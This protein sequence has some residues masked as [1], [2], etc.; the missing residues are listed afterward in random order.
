LGFFCKYWIQ[1]IAIMWVHYFVLYFCEFLYYVKLR[2]SSSKQENE[3]DIS[4]T[5]ENE[6]VFS[7][8]SSLHSSLPTED[9][10]SDDDDIPLKVLYKRFKATKNKTLRNTKHHKQIIIDWFSPTL[11]F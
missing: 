1:V 5:T 6:Q 7:Q 9:T 4:Q 8:D 3:Y 10:K 11:M 2:G